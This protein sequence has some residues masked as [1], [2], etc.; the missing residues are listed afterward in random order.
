MAE[1]HDTAE[2]TL[3]AKTD[4]FEYK[5]DEGT[6]RLPYLENLPMWIIEDGVGKNSGDFLSFAITNLMDEEATTARRALTLQEFNEMTTS[7]IDGSG[8]DLGELFS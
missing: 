2:R 6:I 7:W 3:H 4:L 5:T 8:I 1:K